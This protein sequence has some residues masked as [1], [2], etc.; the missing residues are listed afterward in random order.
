MKV[1]FFLT[2][3]PTVWILGLFSMLCLT[4]PQSAPLSR[5]ASAW[6]P[7]RGKGI[8]VAAPFCQSPARGQNP[9]P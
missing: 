6:S 8:V 2:L 7:G 3:A 5:Q 9:Y 1:S 4:T